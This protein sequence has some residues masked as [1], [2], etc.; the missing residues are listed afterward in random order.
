MRHSLRRLVVERMGNLFSRTRQG[1]PGG[2]HLT[3]YGGEW[4]VAVEVWE[5]GPANS[6]HAES[7]PLAICRAALL[8][9]MEEKP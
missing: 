7:A 1:K 9:V 6:V 5:D 3:S 4:S 2:F 8:A